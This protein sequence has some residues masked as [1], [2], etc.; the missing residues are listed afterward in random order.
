MNTGVLSTLHTPRSSFILH[1]SSFLYCLLVAV[2]C[3]WSAAAVPVSALAADWPAWRGPNR[4]GICEETGLLK[5]WPPAG[6]K[7][8]WQAGGLGEGYG[9]PSIVGNNLYIMGARDGQEWVMAL[10]WTR[11]GRPVWA[12]PIGPVRHE[13]GGYPGPRSTPTIDG[14]RL[15][16]LGI[17]GDL[18]A[19]E[20]KS[21]RGIWRHDLV[22]EFG[23]QAP[24][25]G[26]AESVLIDGDKLACTPGGL[27]ATVLAL[28]KTSGRPLWASPVGDPAEYS[29]LVKVSIGRVIQ[30][31]TLTKN[32]VISVDARD[33]TFLWRY[34][35]PANGTANVPTCV[36]F[37]QTVFA[38]S[39]YGAGGGLVW[40]KRTPSGFEPQELYFTKDMR[41]HHG[42]MVLVD[43]YLY[44]YD[45]GGGLTC[46][47]YQTGQVKWQDKTPGKCSL[48][49]A[50]GM[51]YCRSESGPVSLVEASPDGFGQRGRFDQP[52]R[53][54][55][56]SWPHPV[57]ANGLLFLRDQDV[58]LCYDVGG[59][60]QAGG[61]K[62]RRR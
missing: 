29:S 32:G 17:A 10:D 50:D 45:D 31:V 56:N 14:A 19:L 58:L 20:A 42:G 39:G 28:D 49:Y 12:T 1:P 27:Q 61:R 51:L 34:D 26:Y 5:E 13:G 2:T 35:K 30:Y 25:W 8:L 24:N 6:P 40:A 43:G 9:G 21:G 3:A 11:Q 18:V 15:Y 46:L 22:A 60:A 53:S 23:G 7:L 37:G 55:K 59:G 16:T 52:S 33:G 54:D 38:A 41:N 62:A 36:W 44:G 57:I 47:E 4:D 48:L